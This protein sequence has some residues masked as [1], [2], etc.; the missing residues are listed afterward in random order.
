MVFKEIDYTTAIDF[1]LPRHYSGR[2][3]VVSVAYGWYDQD[4]LMAV[5]T[6][7]K[8]ASPSLCRGI[9]GEE[10]KSSVY[11]LNRLCREEDLTEPLSKFVG[12][13]LRALRS[14]NWIVVSFSDTGMNHNGYIYQATNF[15]YTGVTKKRT[16][17]YTEGN[18]HSRH[19]K[20][21]KQTGLR[22]VRTPKHRYVYF[23]TSDKKLRRLWKEQMRYPVLPYPKGENR[24][25]ELGFVFKQEIV[26]DERKV[27]E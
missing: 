22:K 15:M 26:K 2:K 5:C 25:Y 27:N 7:G 17:M 24:N 13:C 14:K 21:S 4:R 6:F 19:Y 3:P 1:L 20:H 10:F 8:P 11:E 12:L 9:M 16:D 23:C 18:K